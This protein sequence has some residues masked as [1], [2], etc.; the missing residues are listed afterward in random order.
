MEN[1]ENYGKIGTERERSEERNSSHSN[2]I[3]IYVFGAIFVSANPH[4][5]RFSITGNGTNG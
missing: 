4:E 1:I 3:A 2:D 5:K